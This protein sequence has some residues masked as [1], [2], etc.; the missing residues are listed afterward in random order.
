MIEEH[1]DLFGD[2]EQK[3]LRQAIK[4]L[5]SPDYSGGGRA[6]YVDLDDDSVEAR[7][8]TEAGVR[9]KVEAEVAPDLQEVVEL[10]GDRSFSQRRKEVRERYREREDAV[11]VASIR[12][13]CSEELLEIEEEERRSKRQQS[14]RVPSQPKLVQ[15][16]KVELGG[17]SGQLAAVKQERVLTEDTS[18][19][20]DSPHGGAPDAEE[21]A[22]LI[23][24]SPPPTSRST[25]SGVQ[26]SQGLSRHSD[27]PHPSFAVPFAP[28]IPSLNFMDFS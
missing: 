14:Y 11:R 3:E 4:G 18:T 13:R 24:Q 20:L 26:T 28:G 8:E 5:P 9:V 27:I 23:A 25:G 2:R 17:A 21:P 15:R 19:S 6:G 12:R 7:E 1:R 10:D 16:I 22:L